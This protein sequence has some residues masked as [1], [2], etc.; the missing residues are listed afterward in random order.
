MAFTIDENQDEQNPQ[1]GQ[2]SQ[3]LADPTQQAQSPSKQEAGSTSQAAQDNSVKELSS[4]EGGGSP[5]GGA[6]GAG[7]QGGSG[8]GT[9][10]GSYTNLQDYI[11][12]N[13]GG[14]FG[15]QVSSR[16]NNDMGGA[17]QAIQNADQSFQQ[18][19][20]NGTT[21][22]NADLVNSAISDPV[23]LQQNAD[24]TAA[25]KSQLNANYTGPNNLSDQS[26]LYNPAQSAVSTAQ[27]NAQATN[28][29]TGRWALLNQYFGGAGNQYNQGQ[30][31]LDSALLAADP[32][33]QT[34]FQQAQQTAQGLGTQWN[35]MQA[36]D[37]ALAQQAATN[38]AAA[39]SQSRAALGIDANGQLTGTGVIG[40]LQST[41]NQQVTTDNA[42]AA[43]GYNALKGELNSGMLNSNDLQK[44]LGSSFV[45]NSSQDPLQNGTRLYNV[46]AGDYLVD[47]SIQQ[48]TAAN[49][50]TGDQYARMNALS[51]LAGTQNTFL[52]LANSSQ[53][54]TY[55]PNLSFKTSDFNNAVAQQKNALQA[56]LAGKQENEA[57][58]GT[59]M[60]SL[61][62]A[63]NN[64]A[65]DPNVQRGM[66]N[67]PALAATVNK[68]ISDYK[69]ALSQGGYNN[70]LSS[71]NRIVPVNPIGP[72][73][74]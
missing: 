10:S 72:G 38:T 26:D 2:N 31:A 39:N 65:M 63:Y 61:A 8:K 25:L 11:K 9:S 46:H 30:Q 35:Q 29:D 1:N 42:N 19:V 21:N 73:Q 4:G 56:T 28:S 40:N 52:P 15:G 55:N 50:A 32:N 74:I 59:D 54:G 41:I 49:V 27:Q 23:T 17:G 58:V 71:A 6:P 70:T 68:I 36:N 33:A 13:Q 3:A 53:A 5:F 60:H 34:G 51:S 43:A 67:N 18:Q 16:L 66:A 7:G 47:P 22:Y 24:Q 48:A 45:D 12:A 62:D 69:A 20:N 44:Y 14:D 57:Q 64:Y 37:T